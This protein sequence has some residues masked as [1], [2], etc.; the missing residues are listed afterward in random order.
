MGI[1]IVEIAISLEEING[2]LL[3][4]ARYA[5]NIIGRVALQRLEIEELSF[6]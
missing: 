3:A 2:S 6:L 1:E 4:D 5:W